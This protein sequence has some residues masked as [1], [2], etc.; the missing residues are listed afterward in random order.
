MLAFLLANPYALL[1]Y[2]AFHRGLVHQS[3]VSGESQGKLGAP[4]AGGLPYYLWSLTWG[5][6]WLPA[7]AALAGAVVV[8]RSEA[9]LGWLLVPAPILF[10]LFMGLQGR[11]FGRWLLPVFPILCLLAAFMV[12]R[13]AE[14]LGARSPRL[15]PAAPPR[16]STARPAPLH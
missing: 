16:G 9:R 11:Y 12:M 5:L 14:F 6:G 10:L 8:W 1:D 7:L 2:S 15:R 13:T 4:G 3:T